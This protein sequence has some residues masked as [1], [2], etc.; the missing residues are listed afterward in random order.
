METIT[1]GIALVTGSSSGIGRSAAL[2]L[3]ASGW[4]V[5][6]TARRQDAL[7]ETVKAMKDPKRGMVVAADLSK[8]ADVTALFGKI[9]A[10]YGE[11]RPSTSSD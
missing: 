2:A 11:L 10:K 4:T 9:K 3:N 8:A 6:V 5:V 7:E 1:P